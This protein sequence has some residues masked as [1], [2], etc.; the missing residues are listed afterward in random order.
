M[1]DFAS[2]H[3]RTDTHGCA[4]ITVLSAF[5]RPGAFDPSRHAYTSVPLNPSGCL[6]LPL[7]AGREETSTEIRWA[8]VGDKEKKKFEIRPQVGFLF[9]FF[10]FLIYD[11]QRRGWGKIIRR[12][13]VIRLR[14]QRELILR[15]GNPRAMRF[16]RRRGDDGGER[17]GI[18]F[19]E[20]G[21]QAAWNAV[22]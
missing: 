8:R 21:C 12:E 19:R 1:I 22:N 15:R 9:S 6:F 16:V 10:F 3:Y 18:L 11:D 2:A 17:E 5:A 7:A 4:L 14:V 13:F 20:E